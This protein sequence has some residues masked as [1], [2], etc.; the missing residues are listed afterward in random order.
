MNLLMTFDKEI[1]FATGPSVRPLLNYR[2]IEHWR[3]RS[4]SLFDFRVDN[5]Q[6]PAWRFSIEIE[7]HFPVDDRIESRRDHRTLKTKKKNHFDS[8]EVS[9]IESTNS[10]SFARDRL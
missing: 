6:R 9:L 2:N 1:D 5:E 7:F 3:W 8:F 4:P 10:T